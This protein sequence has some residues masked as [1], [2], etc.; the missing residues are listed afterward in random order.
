MSN[1]LPCSKVSKMEKSVVQFYKKLYEETGRLF[2]VYR[3]ETG[4]N[5]SFIEGKYF[6]KILEEQI[7]PNFKNGA[8][9]FSIQEF[10]GH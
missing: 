3:L 9:Y 6:S 10:K 4:A 2:Y 7:K 8:E 1:C 5:F